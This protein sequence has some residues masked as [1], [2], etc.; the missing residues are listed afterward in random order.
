MSYFAPTITNAGLSIPTYQDLLAQMI[1]DMKNI[2]GQDLYL[3][4]DS[5][6]YQLMAVTALKLYDTMQALQLDY[7]SRSPIAATGAALDAVAKLNGIKRKAAQF[8][9]C[10]CTL[11]GTP[12]TVI[13]NGIVQ[14]IGG[15][16]WDLPATVTIGSGGTVTVSAQCE[17]PGAITALSGDI[18]TISTPTSGWISVTNTAAAVGQNAETDA[19]LR[20]RAALSMQ[21]PSQSAFAGTIA[22]IAALPGIGRYRA[23]EGP[24]GGFP[25]HSIG[26]IVEGGVDAD[27]AQAIYNNKTIGCATVGGIGVYVNDAVYGVPAEIRFSRPVDVPIYAKVQ[28]YPLTNTGSSANIIASVKTLIANYLSSLQI[29]D[30]VAVSSLYI[31]IGSMISDITK[32]DFSISL[33]Q[34]G[35]NPDGSDLDIHDVSLASVEVA[36]GDANNITVVVE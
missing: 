30:S 8:S 16:K 34:I 22:A 19:E 17:A 7:N 21:I 2:F 4:N 36:T 35:R 31:I 10:S 11:T 26:C 15:N 32:P 14:D 24:R 5:A 28:I 1:E 13:N 23:Y 27:I 3:G 6:D 20:T 9:S 18:T 25:A 33:I 12:G 29:G